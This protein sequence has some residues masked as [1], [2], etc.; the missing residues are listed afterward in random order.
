MQNLEVYLNETILDQQG[1]PLI[2]LDLNGR[3]SF[4]QAVGEYF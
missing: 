1:L 2:I 3:S 4:C